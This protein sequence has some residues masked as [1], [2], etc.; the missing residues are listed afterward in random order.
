VLAAEARGVHDLES[1]A[2]AFASLDITVKRELEAGRDEVRVMTAHGAKGL[3]APIV[4]LPETTSQSGARG[5]PLMETEE[6]GFL[7]SA[8][9]KA[10]CEASRLARELR[11][12]KETEE[13]LRLLYVAL[14]RARERLVICGR[15]AANRKEETLK[16][17]WAQIRAGFEHENVAPHVRHAASGEVQAQRYG[18]DPRSLPRAARARTAAAVPPAW[19]QA[20]APAE[21]FSRYA[22]PSDLGEGAQSPSP[23]PLAATGGLGR[24]RRGDLIHR[25]LQILPDLAPAERAEGARSLLARERDLTET[26]RAEMTAAALSVLEDARFA[27]V[28]GPGSRAEV[29]VAGSASRLPA[30]LK[31]SGRIDRLV[32]LPD[33]VL[34]ADFKTN[35]PSPTRIED[36]DPAYLR[37]MAIY[38]AVL[39]D[40]FPDRAVEAALVWTDGPKLM[41]IPENLLAQ[42]LGELGRTS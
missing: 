16:G 13:S 21:A 10:D 34:V 9:Q 41:P 17:W 36:A 2:A 11:T 25:L 40:V 4:F 37:Q 32:V 5:S 8:S 31:I 20:V 26:Q 19:A 22:S 30:G 3:E 38:A 7:W 15:I 24:F 39:A 1:L 28:F 18:P 33:R 23:S 14:T 12:R 6:G 27:E 29:S 35:R 42:S